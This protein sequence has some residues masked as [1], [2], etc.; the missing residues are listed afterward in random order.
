MTILHERPV[1]EKNNLLDTLPID[2][3]KWAPIPVA[4]AYVPRDTLPRAP[5]Y[6]PIPA[7]GE[8][9]TPRRSSGKLLG[10]VVSG[11]VLIVAL[12]LLARLVPDVTTET[13]RVAVPVATQTVH[14]EATI[15]KIPAQRKARSAQEPRHKVDRAPVRPKAT[16]IPVAVL[17]PASPTVA[18]TPVV[19]ATKP[20]KKTEES[21]PEPTTT[22]IDDPEPEPTPPPRITGTPHVSV[23]PT[24]TADIVR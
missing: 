19:R 5:Q 14:T 13:P 16:E 21:T 23:T 11:A 7:K 20:P 6:Q 4:P 12:V 17:E 22:P 9:G 24:P 10:M 3:S 18:P 8:T 1:G 2:V 15:T